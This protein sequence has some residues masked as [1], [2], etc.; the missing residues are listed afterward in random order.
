MVRAFRRW[1]HQ[2]DRCPAADRRHWL[3]RRVGV[4][5]DD[6][7]QALVL[8]VI[9]VLLVSIIV[10]VI[11]SQLDAETTA[12][13][14]SVQSESALA[15]AEAGVQEYRNYLDN[16]PN[17]YAFDY[18]NP[19]G[20]V[21]LTG[22]KQVGSTD[23]WFHYVP[24]S[25][26]AVTTGGSAGQ[27]L[28]EVTGR[29]GTAGDYSYRSLLV[30]YKLSGILTDSYYSEYELPD[31]N[32][33]GVLGNATVTTSSGSTS[34]PLTAISVE[35][36]YT[37]A[38]GVTTTY[39]PM[40]LSDA[41]CKYH[42]YDENTFVD[43]LGSITNKW[44]GGGATLASASNPYYGPLYDGPKVVYNVP[45]NA[46]WPNAGA[47]IK[48]N[49]GSGV[50]SA[51]GPGFYPSAS[52]F[53]GIFYTNDQPWLCGNPVFNG[54]PP[55]ESGV[56]STF[57]YRD[58][59]SGAVA[60]RVGSATEYVPQGWVNDYY[61][62][63]KSKPVFGATATPK[64]PTLGGQQHLPPTTAGLIGYA[65]GAQ[66]NGCLYT[67]P[68][69]IEFVKGGTM[70]VWSPLTANAEPDFTTGTP[71]DCGHFSPAKPFVTGLT[72]PNGVIYVESEQS[73]GPNSAFNTS[74][75]PPVASFISEGA[76]PSGATCLNPYYYNDARTAAACS[77]GDAVI[78]GELSGQ[79]TL[80][81]S[82]GIIVSHDV[83]YG[84][85][86]GTGGASTTN[87]SAVPACNGSGTND[88]LGLLSDSDLIVSHPTSGNSNV[89]ASCSDG[90]A[91]T[92]GLSDVVPWSCDIKNPIIDAAAVTL[93]GATYVQ[94]FA[95]GRGLGNLYQN[96]TNINYYPGFNGTTSNNGYNQVLSY[97]LRLG[98]LSPPHLLQAT[99]SVWDV[100]GFVVCGNVNSAGFPTVT[101]GGD[102]YQQVDCPSLP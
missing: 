10:P 33:P 79:V 28:L 32:Q 1:T 48:I 50:C 14:R 97:D 39:G 74:G 17:Y 83:T 81:T 71:A 13:A 31:P 3:A 41:L 86:D 49:G 52:V 77:E 65:D 101:S 92:L 91:S 44:A 53:N 56:P 95:T 25:R 16:V 93:N 102:I 59:W 36:D 4:S 51:G 35:Y 5:R 70:N 80:A 38:A 24:D 99:D 42:T 47:T 60:K 66:A 12:I 55:L 68:T 29:A 67:G 9:I 62:A 75:L 82:A 37:D 21:A 45:N 54:S 23:E 22:W 100:T 19:N 64:S 46:G 84:C 90:T 69:M 72:V 78:S 43:S 26:L 76:L 11:A 89:A 58:A 96:G 30:S 2:S 98:Y 20:D 88:V 73:S 34:L 63:C 27:M 18:G 57:V 7:G 8:A 85:A 40:S 15:A 94:N 87:P 6:S 61:A